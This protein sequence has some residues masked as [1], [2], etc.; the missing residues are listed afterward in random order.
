M[1]LYH[2]FPA[3]ASGRSIT[4]ICPEKALNPP[5][6]AT[7]MRIPLIGATL[8]ELA[9]GFFGIFLLIFALY[10]YLEHL[11]IEAVMEGI[12][13][14]GEILIAILVYEDCT[15]AKR[16]S[17]IWKT[18]A[19][20]CGVFSLI[21]FW[22]MQTEANKREREDEAAKEEQHPAKQFTPTQQM[23]AIE[24]PGCNA[25]MKVPKL[26]KMQTVTCDS[27]GLSG[28]IEV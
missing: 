11:N 8:T 28:E 18:V 14:S 20:G 24:C 13:D 4:N 15:E 16:A 9:S 17:N 7:P 27:C 22:S 21:F 5:D 26:G 12:C 19:I 1:A 2:P 10:A 3:T 6:T 25:Q 23:T